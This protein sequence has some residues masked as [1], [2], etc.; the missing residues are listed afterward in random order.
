MHRPVRRP[1]VLSPPV[2]RPRPRSVS[3]LGTRFGTEPRNPHLHGMGGLLFLPSI[4]LISPLPAVG[5]PTPGLGGCIRWPSTGL[6]VPVPAVA[7]PTPGVGSCILWPSMGLIVPVPAVGTPGEGALDGA[8]LL[9]VGDALQAANRSPKP[10]SITRGKRGM[11]I[12]QDRST[13]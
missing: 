10:Y 12:L 3:R 6:M 2:E 8:A 11:W 1:S 9:E 5:M 4:G 7:L 13:G